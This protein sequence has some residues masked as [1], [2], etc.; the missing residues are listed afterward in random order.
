MLLSFTHE[1]SLPFDNSRAIL[2]VQDRALGA[3]SAELRESIEEAAA[4]P[5]ADERTEEILTRVSAALKRGM[6]DEGVFLCVSTFGRVYD[7]LRALPLDVPIPEIVVESERVIGLDW[8]EGARRVLTVTVNDT[9]FLGFAA[10]FGH[11]PLH[12]RM[13]FDGAIPETSESTFCAAFTPHS[14]QAPSALGSC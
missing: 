14:A 13:P 4:P 5:L 9:S 10:L 2:S 6:E 7:L 11:E 3:D 12:G 8:Q 1:S